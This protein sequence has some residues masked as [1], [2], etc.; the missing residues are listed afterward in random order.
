MN[1]YVKPARPRLR[2]FDMARH[3][4]PQLPTDYRLL[5]GYLAEYVR[6]VGGLSPGYDFQT[7]RAD[8]RITARAIQADDDSDFSRVIGCG[9]AGISERAGGR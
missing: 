8:G 9:V 3:I 2:G 6:D 7:L 5:P 1:M 4:A